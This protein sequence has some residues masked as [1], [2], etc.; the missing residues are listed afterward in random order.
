MPEPVLARCIA[1]ARAVSWEY[2][3]ACVHEPSRK[4]TNVHYRPF[5]SILWYGSFA[6]AHRKVARTG[7][8]ETMAWHLSVTTTREEDK[9]TIE[10]L[11]LGTRAL[12]TTIPMQSSSDREQCTICN[13]HPWR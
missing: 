2:E 13:H 3:Q 5:Y 10:V 11:G 9:H 8:M 7:P 12:G 4:S 6:D 1:S